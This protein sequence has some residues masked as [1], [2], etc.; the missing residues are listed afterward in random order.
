MAS[1]SEPWEQFSREES[2]MEAH[3]PQHHTHANDTKTETGIDFTW[4]ST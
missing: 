3:T 4:A 1:P 2:Q